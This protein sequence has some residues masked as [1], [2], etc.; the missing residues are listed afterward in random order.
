[1][2][3][4]I[5]KVDATSAIAEDI[6][7]LRRAVQGE[8]GRRYALLSAERVI[9]E[10]RCWLGNGACSLCLAVVRR[11]GA[12]WRGRGKL[13][14]AFFIEPIRSD[15]GRYL[16]FLRFLRCSGTIG[17]CEGLVPARSGG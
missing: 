7:Q 15:T 1:M 4:V 6:A 14:P 16:R 2:R 3:R 8:A 17:M 12:Q 10:V 11:A 13:R 5:A 9:W